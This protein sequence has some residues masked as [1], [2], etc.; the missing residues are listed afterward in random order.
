MRDEPL[1]A[2]RQSAVAARAPCPGLAPLLALLSPPSRAFP[3]Q[4]VESEL[5]CLKRHRSWVGHS[6][7][8]AASGAAHVRISPLGLLPRTSP[9]SLKRTSRCCVP[10]PTCV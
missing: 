8:P 7:G 1:G 4:P 5:S 9:V 3:G 10:D 6:R 2:A